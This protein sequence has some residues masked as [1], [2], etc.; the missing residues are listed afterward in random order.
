MGEK[1][2]V[3]MMAVTLLILGSV[4]AGAVRPGFD[5]S[6]LARNDDSS[7]GYYSMRADKLNSSQLVLID[8]SDRDAG[9]FDIE[10]NYDQ[11]V[12]ETG[13]ASAGVNGP[14]GQSARVGYSN[15][16]GD[17]ETFFELTGSGANR[18]FLDSSPT[19]LILASLNSS[20]TGQYVFPVIN[21][22]PQPSGQTP[23]PEAL[24]L[25][26]LGLSLVGSLR[27]RRTL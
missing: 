10:F 1:R 23:A 6:F 24:R 19:G 14:G 27:R 2:I 3:L 15:G 22:L 4:R 7:I 12:W 18:Y 21:G 17:A 11:I 9:D 5:A 26:G 8:R 20:I 13:G 16:S 25:G